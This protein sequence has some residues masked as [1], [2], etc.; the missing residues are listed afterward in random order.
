MVPS[1]WGEQRHPVAGM[2]NSKYWVF[3]GYG[4]SQMGQAFSQGT[5]DSEDP[6]M[7][8]AL[9]KFLTAVDDLLRMLA[10]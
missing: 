4:W 6:S 5:P 2:E 9:L 10:Q 7:G 3:L 1:H 8:F